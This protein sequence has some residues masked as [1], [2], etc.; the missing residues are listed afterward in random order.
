LEVKN[1]RRC[2]MSR[3]LNLKILSD[4]DIEKIHKESLRILREIGVRFPHRGLLEVFKKK[5][6]IVDFETEIVK[7]PDEVIEDAIKKQRENTDA[8]FKKHEKFDENDYT[9]KFFMSGGNIKHLIEPGTFKRKDGNLRDMLR[10]IVI[11]N[12]LENVSRV[13]AFLTPKNYDPKLA[14]IIQ[15]YL[16]SLY[17]KKRY[18]FTYIYSLNSAKCLIDMARVVAEDDFQFK[19]GSLIEYEI[20]PCANLEFSKEHLEI[21]AEFSKN[22]MTL[23][24][25]HWAWMGRHTPLTYASLLALTNANILAGT[26]VLMALNPDNPYYRYIF[27][28]HCVN[29]KDTDLP[30]MGNPNQIIFAWAARQLADFY[31]F[32]YCITNSGFSDAIEDNFQSGFE[33]GVTAAL[34]IAAG[35]TCLGVKGIVGIDQGVSFERLV[36]DNEMIDYLNFIF[37]KKIEVNEETFDFDSIKKAGIGE[38][39]LHSLEN[40]QRVRDMYWDSDFFY[41]GSY[42]NWRKNISSEKLKS[43]IDKILKDNYPPKLLISEDK[44]KQLDT[45]MRSHVKD[46]SFADKLKK[47]LRKIVKS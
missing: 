9:Q 31:G 47:D 30:L 2:K 42:E 32:Q 16:L 38:N 11:G 41:S 7:F 1:R 43:K 6:A 15:F 36:T 37:C 21:A 3:R 33:V 44:V 10:A 13:S 8:Y 20:E 40:E 23:A 39:F 12:E 22:N 19:N 34:S 45:V 24:T 29:R 4:S 27:P 5:G 26:A 18:F 25:T 14:D 17:S 46:K 28:T 35:V